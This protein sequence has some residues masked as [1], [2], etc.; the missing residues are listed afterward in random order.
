MGFGGCIMYI[1]TIDSGTTN[2]RVKIWHDEKVVADSQVEAGVRDTAVTGSKYKLQQGVKNAIDS[3]V[4]NAGITKDEVKLFLASGMITSGLGLYELSH[5]WAPAGVKELSES[6]ECKV[7]NEVIDKPIWFVPGIKNNLREIN[8]DNCE[9]MDIMRG[10]EVETFGILQKLKINGPALIILP[11]SHSKFVSLNSDNQVTGCVTTLAGELLSVITCNTIL[12]NALDNSFAKEISEEFILK[13]AHY[14]NKVG[15]NRTCFT[16]RILDMFTKYTVNEKANFLLGAVLASD[17]FAI[18]NSKALNI[19]PDLPVI[20][21]GSKI[22]KKAFEILI[23]SDNY[24][25]GNINVVEEEIMKDMAGF[26][27]I[28]IA[29]HRGLI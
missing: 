12:A 5:V 1:A 11:G 8:M 22:L 7:I 21:G 23:K 27:A 24:F 15:L 14:S 4:S 9:L 25:K 20:I 26:G 13:G 18:K 29:K 6:M 2:T 19:S 3:A 10:E 28:V 16:V 17:L